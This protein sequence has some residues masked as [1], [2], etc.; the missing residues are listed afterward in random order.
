MTTT[1]YDQCPGCGAEGNRYHHWTCTTERINTLSS[2]L[3]E[4]EKETEAAKQAWRDD[5][6]ETKRERN[7]AL[8]ERDAALLRLDAIRKLVAGLPPT[9]DPVLVARRLVDDLKEAEG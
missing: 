9:G 7:E 6:E 8:K 5:R 2:K 1:N 4:A 3:S